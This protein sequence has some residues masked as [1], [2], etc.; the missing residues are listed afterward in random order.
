M[1]ISAKRWQ[2]THV[3]RHI[4]PFLLLN[5]RIS[6]AEGKKTFINIIRSPLLRIVV[7]CFHLVYNHCWFIAK[8]CFQLFV[9]VLSFASFFCFNLF[10][11]FSPFLSLSL[12]I[13]L[14]P[15]F[16][17]I[18][19]FYFLRSF[20]VYKLFSFSLFRV[21]V[22]NIDLLCFVFSWFLFKKTEKIICIICSKCFNINTFQTAAFWTVFLLRIVLDRNLCA[23]FCHPFNQIYI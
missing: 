4:H 23:N 21:F 10:I 16:F 3:G 7:F 6:S 2:A 9:V 22:Y 11:R 19:G 18:L 20:H 14:D 5:K 17:F 1:N 8:K 12:P 13:W 15:D